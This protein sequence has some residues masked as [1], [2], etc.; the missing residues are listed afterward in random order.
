MRR[1]IVALAILT[2]SAGLAQAYVGP[3]LGMGALGAVVGLVF[4]V[5]L[6]VVALVWYPIKRALG[7]GKRRAPGQGQQQSNG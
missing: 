1:T 5:L 6:A 3:G 2:A 4:S 7:L